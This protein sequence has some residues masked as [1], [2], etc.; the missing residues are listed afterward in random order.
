MNVASGKRLLIMGL[1]FLTAAACGG[2]GEAQSEDRVRRLALELA[3]EV[4]QAVGLPF[5]SPPTIAVRS[6]QQVRAYLAHK[7]EEEFAPGEF[8]L[9]AEAY[10]LFGMIPDTADLKELLLSLYAEQV[11]GYYDPDSSALYVVE[12]AGP[13]VL[14]LTLAHELVHALQGQHVALDSLLSIEGNNDR[15]MAAQ[16]VMEGQAT[17]ASARAILKDRN[18]N[19]MPDLWWEYRRLVRRQ[20]EQMPV[21]ANAPL[22]IREGLLF[23]YLAGADF[24]R[25]FDGRYSDTVPFG[26]R[27]P[28]STEQILHTDRYIEKDRPV[29][30]DVDPASGVL[31]DDNLGEFE[32][33]ILLTELLG[34]E[35]T[36][37][38][39][40]LGWEGDRYALYEAG[41]DEYAL[42]WWSVWESQR[43]ATR[44]ATLLERG[45]TKRERPGR[46]SSIERVEI[47]G[48]AGVR[49]VNAPED[50][51]GWDE[52]PRV[53]AVVN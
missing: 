15:R 38:A 19:A 8:E 22:V 27:L 2:R 20:Q 41:P 37:T 28:E 49:L 13:E 17:L 36:A 32:T 1:L 21:F 48:L 9:V 4:E 40:A 24:V 43:A 23:S 33:R 10:T 5:L 42:V 51:P 30:L 39:G 29:E 45:W 25:W 18:L 12:G 31:Y 26:P 35:S 16:A 34:S 11:V 6:P 44:F 7:L 14:R 53:K 47:D 46:R 3:P 50:W 52:L